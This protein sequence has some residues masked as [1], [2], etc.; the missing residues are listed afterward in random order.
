[1]CASARVCVCIC[2][3]LFV[4]V[5]VYF[6]N[7]GEVGGKGFRLVCL[8]AQRMRSA[9]L[10]SRSALPRKKLSSKRSVHYFRFV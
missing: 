1:M 2:A 4:S 6:F 5:C 10:V 7:R 3:C 8:F 9:D